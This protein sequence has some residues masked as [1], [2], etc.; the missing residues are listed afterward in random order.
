MDLS[1]IVSFN[2]KFWLEAAKLCSF[3]SKDPST[4]TGAII[5]KNGKLIRGGYNQFAP[6][7]TETEERLNNRELKYK[8]IVHCEQ[9]AILE[10]NREDLKG[11][12]LYTYPFMSCSGCAK[13]VIKAGITRCVAPPLPADK[14]DRW[15]EDMKI[16]RMQFEEAGVKLDIIDFEGVLTK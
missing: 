12:T 13:L 1:S 3:Q 9:N 15:E 10:S 4:K 16:A 8:L 6:G 14:A 2:D 5:V 11:A 7:I